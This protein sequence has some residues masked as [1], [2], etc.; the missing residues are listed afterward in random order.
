MLTKDAVHHSIECGR[1]ICESKRHHK[2]LIKTESR[3]KCGRVNV[4]R[5]NA[6]LI[7]TALEIYPTKV[8]RPLKL[9]KEILNPW[10]RKLILNSV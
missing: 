9:I 7:I 4:F 5:Y 6:N 2:K 10:N 3:A 8:G 1:R